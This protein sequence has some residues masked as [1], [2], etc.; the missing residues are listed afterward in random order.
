MFKLLIF[1]GCIHETIS[2]SGHPLLPPSTCGFFRH[3]SKILY[4]R[5]HRHTG[6]LQGEIHG[7]DTTGGSGGQAVRWPVEGN[8]I[9]DTKNSAQNGKIKP[10]FSCAKVFSKRKFLLRLLCD[11]HSLPRW[12]LNLRYHQPPFP[13]KAS[14][15]KSGGLDR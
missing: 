13:S 9:C 10:K 12:I 2:P 15:I 1:L 3:L 6:C 4:M 7:N 5:R 11:S 8:Y 14:P